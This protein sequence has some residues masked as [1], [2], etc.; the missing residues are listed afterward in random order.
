MTAISESLNASFGSPTGAATTNNGSFTLLAPQGTNSTSLVV[1]LG[2]ASTGTA[3]MQTGTAVINLTSDGS[4][5]S[6][7]GTT[8]LTPQTVTVQGNVYR[9]ASAGVPVSV[10]AGNIHCGGSF[11]TQRGDY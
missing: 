6:G 4:G 8:G 7:L 1:G 11:G 5:T 3:G 9:L 10:N 2:N